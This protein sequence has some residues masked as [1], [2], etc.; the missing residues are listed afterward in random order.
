[1]DDKLGGGGEVQKA[2][3]RVVDAIRRI[4]GCCSDAF[5]LHNF[6]E[7]TYRA[8][9]GRKQ[10]MVLLSRGGFSMVAMGVTGRDAVAWK[11][12]FI[13]AFDLMTRHII[14]LSRAA[15]RR[16]LLEWQDA[17]QE[18]KA[19][20]RELA[21]VLAN[22]VAY[23][24]NQGSRH[25]D[26]YFTNT[27]RMVY[28]TFFQLSPEAERRLRHAIRDHL[29]AR[30]L[31]DLAPV[32]DRQVISSKSSP[33]PCQPLLDLLVLVDSS[34]IHDHVQVLARIFAVEQF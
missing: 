13:T 31:R 7:T 16:S 23:A 14:E 2:H 22:F 27:T 5:R 1:M 28:R 12:K 11:E 29:D 6:V 4:M 33:L 8:D 20:R 17:R 26:T 15:E 25:A 18:G 9:H 24:R 10:P 30:Q 32:E 3:D 21:A 34:I 19:T